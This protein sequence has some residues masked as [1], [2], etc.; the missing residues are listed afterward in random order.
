MYGGAVMEEG[1]VET[2]LGDARHPYTRALLDGAAALR[3]AARRAAQAIPGAAPRPRRR[4][5]GCPFAG[6]CPRTAERLPRRAPPPVALRGGSCRALPAGR[7]AGAADMSAPLLE[8]VDLEEDLHARAAE[9]VRAAPAAPRGRRRELRGAGRA[10]VRRRR[11]IG[12]RQIDAGARGHGAGARRPRAKCG[13]KGARCSRLSRRELKAARAHFQ[14]IFQD[15]YGSLDP[16]QSVERIVAEP[17]A[18]LE[19]V[20][21]RERARAGRARRSRRSAS[22]PRRRGNIRMNSRAASASASPSRAR[23]SRGRNW[24]SPTSRS[25]RSTFRSRRRCSI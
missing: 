6:R 2:V 23:W 5:R 15:P 22:T 19:H 11:R 21:A 9:L 3:R 18:N 7:S 16:R 17:L 14:M 12:L 13:S 24:S 25:R 20:A 10:L 1:P 4:R 8:V